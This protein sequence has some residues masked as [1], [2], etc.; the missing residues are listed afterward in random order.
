MRVYQGLAIAFD[1]ANKWVLVACPNPSALGSSK[2]QPRKKNAIFTTTP[3]QQVV[4]GE[5]KNNSMICKLE[6][7]T[8]A[9]QDLL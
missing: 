4:T 1:G 6:P 8:V 7:K 3:K 5:Q 9:N 2:N